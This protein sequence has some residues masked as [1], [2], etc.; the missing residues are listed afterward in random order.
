MAL[1]DVPITRLSASEN[2]NH[3]VRLMGTPTA[4]DN[5][6]LRFWNVGQKRPKRLEG[7]VDEDSTANR[8]PE[9]DADELC[10]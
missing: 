8:K 2:F 3:E 7:F 6:E 5:S 4:D 10:Y 9:Y 1:D